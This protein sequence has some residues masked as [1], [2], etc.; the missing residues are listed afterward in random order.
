MSLK[1]I[2]G[3]PT[4]ISKFLRERENKT[5]YLELEDLR[6]NRLLKPKMYS[7]DKVKHIIQEWDEQAKSKLDQLEEI[8]SKRIEKLNK[9]I[10]E[11]KGVASGGS[12][13]EKQ[14]D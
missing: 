3:T 4:E 7:Y 8:Y 5:P 12:E 14:K 10:K 9:R 1:I 6:D 11:L 2:D 13:H